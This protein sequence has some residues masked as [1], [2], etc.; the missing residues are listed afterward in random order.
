M[1]A[2]GS[3]GA[4]VQDMSFAQLWLG[5]A[6]SLNLNNLNAFAPTAI[7]AYQNKFNP[8]VALPKGANPNHFYPLS[9]LHY[10]FQFDAGLLVT[11]LSRFAKDKGVIHTIDKVKRVNNNKAGD[12]SSLSLVKQGNRSGDLFVDCSGMAGVLNQRHFKC[13]YLDWSNYLPCDSAI[14]M[15]TGKLDPLPPYTK[16]I[17]MN[18]GWRWQIPLRTRT[19]NGYVFS[20]QFIDDNAAIDEFTKSL[21]GQEILTEPRVIKFKT[22][23]LKTP[24]YKNS[25]AIGLS[26]GFFEPLESTSIHLIHKFA[27]ELR[28]ALISNNTREQEV[29]AFNKM[30]IDTGIQIRDF[31]VTHY[32]VTR[33]DDSEFWR[34]CQTMPIPETLQAHLEEFRNTGYISLDETSLFSYESYLQVLVG[35]QYLASYKNLR[36]SK[37]N[38]QGAKAFLDNVHNAIINEV[39][40]LE[41]HDNFLK[42]ISA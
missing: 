35:Q 15:Q 6:D 11:Q 29:R 27:V 32:H 2:F 28:E 24:W 5:S 20:S 18:A 22:G 13:E 1:H 40:K 14:P 25:V 31:L 7:A 19:G 39:S 3:L 41:P 12:I 23:C 30:F 26:S 17:A 16:S 38:P 33:R 10:A 42:K 37:L 34:H 21:S 4:H 36:S 8:P 9:D